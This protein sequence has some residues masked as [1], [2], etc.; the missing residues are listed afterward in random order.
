M[1][2]CHRMSPATLRLRP[3]C[4]ITSSRP[5]RPTNIRAPL[6]SLRNCRR[7]E[8]ENCS[9]LPCGKLRCRPQLRAQQASPRNEGKGDAIVSMPKGPTLAV[10]PATDNEASDTGLQIL[11]PSGWPIPKGYANGM[12]ADGRIVVTGGVI[13][14][15]IAGELADG[16]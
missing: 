10:L 15:N 4:R 2:C 16:F 5:S 7:R 1:W 3:S 11:R 12:A 14:W 6:N 13:G 8:P 9:D